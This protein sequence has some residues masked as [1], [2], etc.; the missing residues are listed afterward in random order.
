MSC[1]LLLGQALS[2]RVANYKIDVQFND[3]DKTLKGKQVINWRNDSNDTISTLQ[4]HLYYNA[5]KNNQ[6]TFYQ[7]T[8]R[9]N[10]LKSIE[11][12]GC[13]WS[14]SEITSAIIEGEELIKNLHYIQPDD[15]NVHDQSVVEL[16]LNREVAPGESIGINFLWKAKIPKI[17]VRTGYN[18]EFYFFAQ[19]F[20]KIG[21]YEPGNICNDNVGQW[22]CHQYHASGEYY[23]DFGNYNVSITTPSDYILGASGQLIEK[24]KVG[25]LITWKYQLNDVIDFAWAAS[26]HFSEQKTEWNHVDLN[27]MTY[28]GHEH[29]A[30]RYFGAVMNALEYM[31]KYLGPY[32]YETLTIIDPPIHG[33]FTGGMEYPTLIT[34][35]S[36]CFFP[37]G[38]RTTETLTVH[39]FIHQYFMQM[40]A[41]NE[42]ESPW[43]DEGITTY[44]EGRIMDHYYGSQSSTIDW[45]GITAGNAE[46][47]RWELMKS[48]NP[49]IGANTFKSR[50]FKHGGYGVISYNKTAVWLKTLEGIVGI[51]TM[52]R[53]MKTYFDQWKFDHPCAGDFENVVNE[54]IGQDKDSIFDGDM[55]WFFDQVIRGTNECDY[56]VA[57]ISNDNMEP[58]EGYISS[59]ENCENPE[60]DSS[61]KVYRSVVVLHR[62]GEIKIPVEVSVYFN[63]GSMVVE[64]WDGKSRSKSFEYLGDKKII[65]AI[66]DEE[67]KIYLDNNFINNSLSVH[68][69]NIGVLYYFTH[70]LEKFQNLMLGMSLFI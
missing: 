69:D 32:P 39:E 56:A 11:N 57:S 36:F 65:R 42:Q 19:W 12:D 14:Y 70:F 29:C 24:I 27:L 60:F 46:F 49:K 10:L 53:I 13:H 25:E 62:L 33:I 20:P 44:Y 38:I 63:D 6:S 66:I 30:E 34:S 7:G 50:D 47:N 8:N 22:K 1:N 5:F 26:P 2:S 54:V 9:S 18:K 61:N 16:T 21:R 51:N 17:K 58:P 45:L 40:V 4:F 64:N 23:A 37:E 3:V 15:G 43:M 48:D 28:P 31:T 55:T 68:V 67:R 52:D 41:T 35:V 59:L